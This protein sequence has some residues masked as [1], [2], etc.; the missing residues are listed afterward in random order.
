MSNYTGL[1]VVDVGVLVVEYFKLKEEY[2]NQAI[3]EV[4]ITIRFRFIHCEV[5]LLNYNNRYTH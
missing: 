4:R 1:V 5:Y 2:L 3:G